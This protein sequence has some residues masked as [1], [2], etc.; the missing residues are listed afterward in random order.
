MIEL[1][2]FDLHKLYGFILSRCE[3]YEESLEEFNQALNIQ[4]DG[5]IYYQMAYCYVYLR[6][7]KLA[8]KYALVAIETEYDAY[9]LYQ[10]IT[11]GN[12]RDYGAVVKVLKEGVKKKSSSACMLY[13]DYVEFFEKEK[14]LEMAFEYAKPSDRGLV[15]F[16]LSQKYKMLEVQFPNMVKDKKSLHYMKIYNEYGLSLLTANHLNIT[17]F[18]EYEENN[19]HDVIQMLF[20]RFDADAELIFLL[21]LLEKQFKETGDT[22]IDE[23]SV[24]YYLINYLA[25][26]EKNQVCK[27]LKA[28]IDSEEHDAMQ[29]MFNLSRSGN[30][31]IPKCYKQPFD[32]FLDVYIDVMTEKATA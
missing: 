30:Y 16:N 7:Y 5:Q 13:S 12:L 20:N 3:K 15:A 21:M 31:S 25:T 17:L 22:N 27:L 29:K 11:W 24:I 1:T 32:L 18:D 2:N 26:K 10:Q 8:Q 23:T 9:S 6:E 28:Y 19:D 4:Q 14:Y